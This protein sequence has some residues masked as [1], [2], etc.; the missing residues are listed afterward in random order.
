[1]GFAWR[2]NLVSLISSLGQF[3]R[4]PAVSSQ[5]AIDYTLNRGQLEAA[6]R[7]NWI[8][9]K[10]VDIPADDSTRQWRRWIAEDEQVTKL[11]GAE[12]ELHLR[13]RL[14][15]AIK[16]SRL[17]GG[18]AL[19]MG[20][21]GCGNFWDELDP[22]DVKQGA[23]KFVHVITKDMIM[24]GPV[25]RDLGS[26]WFGHPQ[27]YQRQSTVI[28]APVNKVEA[29]QNYLGL[30]AGEQLD[31]HPSRV[32]RLV[33]LDY[34]DEENAPDCWGD[35]VLQPVNSAIKAAGIVAQ[36]VAGLTNKAA[37][38]L[39]KI[40]D[41]GNKLSTQA[42]TDELFRRFSAAQDGKSVLNALLLDINEE[43]EQMTVNFGGL[44]QILEMYLSIAAGAVDIPATRF[45][46]QSPKGL[47]A[48]GESDQ[49]NYYDRVKSDQEMRL[50]PVM[51]PLDEVLI[52][53]ALGSR[54]PEIDYEWKSLWQMNDHEKAELWWKKAQAHKIDVDAGLVP[55]DALRIAR[56]NQLIEDGT[57]PGLEQALDDCEQADK[58]DIDEA[59]LMS[60][61]GGETHMFGGGPMTPEAQS[62]QMKEQA[63]LAPKPAPFGKKPAAGGPRDAD[64]FG[65]AGPPDEER[66]EHGK[67]T[68]GG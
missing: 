24:A 41:L 40:P 62:A 60:I 55:P 26:P 37:V 54:D 12:K 43:W 23:L 52:R 30:P 45:L 22:D 65:D 19:V 53:H 42:G 32:I 2:D 44:P 34:P 21:E 18:A 50:T 66:D 46:S 3:G 11:E 14:R 13:T 1:M 67:W 15:D 38:D 39:I 59:N 51:T 64:P 47:N 33:G 58:D 9:R 36:S 20:V 29:P 10:C 16:K 6:Y 17:Y 27:W 35:S 28:P 25:I 48:T 5:Y 4:D 57:Y 63:A 8:A 68:A 31:I 49:R 56:E 7:G 61:T